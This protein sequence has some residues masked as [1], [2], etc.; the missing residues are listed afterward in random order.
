MKKKSFSLGKRD[1]N[2]K[3]MKVLLPLLPGYKGGKG[4][5]ERSL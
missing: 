5:A 4:Q 3:Y 2:W 1:K